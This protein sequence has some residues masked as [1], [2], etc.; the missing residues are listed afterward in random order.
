VARP[1]RCD[2]RY[3]PL[4]SQGLRSPAAG[5]DR[6]CRCTISSGHE[7]S[8][9]DAA[10]LQKGRVLA[11]AGRDSGRPEGAEAA[12][13]LLRP[14]VGGH[15]DFVRAYLWLQ[16]AAVFDAEA[17]YDRELLARVMTKA[18]LSEAQAL[19]AAYQP[20]HAPDSDREAAVAKVAPT[21]EQTKGGAT[22][23]TRE[24]AKRKASNGYFVKL[25]VFADRENAERLKSRLR[26]QGDA[27]TLD[28]IR[29]NGRDLISVRVGPYAERGGQIPHRCPPVPIRRS[30]AT[31]GVGAQALSVNSSRR[32]TRSMRRRRSAISSAR[33][34]ST[35]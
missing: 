8:G 17:E 32:S 5:D 30:R 3:H 20:G 21:G 11:A 18:Q 29:R 26:A 33:A 31:A 35:A 19:V 7:I 27:V 10:G 23:A 2:L 24:G 28:K 25:G 6:F 34:A 15:P 16:L 12:W 1:T 4:C 22:T 9:Y 13:P 14:R